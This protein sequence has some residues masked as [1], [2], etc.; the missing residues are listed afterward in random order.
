MESTIGVV[1]KNS[2]P[3]LVPLNNKWVLQK[4]I[5]SKGAHNFENNP[6]RDSGWGLGF[7][8]QGF[9]AC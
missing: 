5:Y 8:V 6:F 9:C 4:E 1:P 7:R 3:I 2:G